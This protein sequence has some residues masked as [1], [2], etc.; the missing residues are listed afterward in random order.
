M[1]A[2]S[3]AGTVCSK[4]PIVTSY[5]QRI[6]VIV[7]TVHAGFIPSSC[8]AIQGIHRKNSSGVMNG[9]MPLVRNQCGAA[10]HQTLVGSA[11]FTA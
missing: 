9:G 10:S 5:S 2:A 11:G 8:G 6:E 1:S 3:R 4:H 7:V